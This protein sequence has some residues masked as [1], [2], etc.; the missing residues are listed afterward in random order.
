MQ[1]GISQ[2]NDVLETIY[3]AQIENLDEIIIKIKKEI[4]KKAIEKDKEE[5]LKKIDE[6]ERETI[7]NILE[8]I[9]ENY[10][11]KTSEYNKAMYKQGF[12][13]GINLMLECLK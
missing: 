3:K 6:K 12:K 4:D 2:N 5:I 1:K 7:K 8:E 10:S 11:I 13:D 9:E